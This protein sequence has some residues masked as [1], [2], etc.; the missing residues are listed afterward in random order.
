[1]KGGERG[2]EGG[3]EGEGPLCQWVTVHKTGWGE[4]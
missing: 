3:T 1:M 4:E 2:E